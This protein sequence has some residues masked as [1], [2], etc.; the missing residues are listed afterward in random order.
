MK[1][2]TT[3]GEVEIDMAGSAAIVPGVY[4]LLDRDEVVYVGMSCD[5]LPRIGDHR[6]QGRKRFTHYAFVYVD[7][8]NDAVRKEAELIARFNPKYNNS[9]GAALWDT[10]YG[11]VPN[12][13]I[14]V[15]ATP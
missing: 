3:C 2:Q 1:L 15:E 8:Y 12:G 13:W 14:K 5:I 11:K 9:P 4:L 7:A 10:R 6:R